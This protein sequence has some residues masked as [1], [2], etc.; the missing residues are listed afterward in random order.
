MAPSCVCG[1]FSGHYA[2]WFAMPAGFRI[3]SACGCVGVALLRLIA[4]QGF[5][6]L[7]LFG[8]RCNDCNNFFVAWRLPKSLF[9]GL[10]PFGVSCD[11]DSGDVAML[12]QWHVMQ[13]RVRI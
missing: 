5:S 12:V 3:R 2:A 10:Q 13:H 4:P 7:Q 6:D 11:F 8:I 9:A 1:F